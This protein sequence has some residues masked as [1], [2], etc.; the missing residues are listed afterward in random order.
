M[1][2]NDIKRGFNHGYTLAQLK[3]ELAKKLAEGFADKTHPYAEAFNSGIQELEKEMQLEKTRSKPINI[4]K[5]KK[6]NP[7]ISKDKNKDM[8][9]HDK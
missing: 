3:P 6:H 5:Y 4:L 1:E 9:D 8:E 2:L 7:S